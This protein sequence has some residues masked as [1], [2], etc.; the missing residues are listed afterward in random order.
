MHNLSLVPRPCYAQ[1]VKRE[2]SYFIMVMK[3]ERDTLRRMLR[4]EERPRVRREMLARIK[5]LEHA[6]NML[7]LGN[8]FAVA[9]IMATS[10][11]R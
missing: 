8:A 9:S 10:L 7:F 11:R 3:D 6:S 1:A 5:L 2:G 4:D